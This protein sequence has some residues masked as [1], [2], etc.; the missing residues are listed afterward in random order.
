MWFLIKKKILGQGFNI[1]KSPNFWLKMR[2]LLKSGLN[3]GYLKHTLKKYNPK[4]K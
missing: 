3:R 2:E 4:L 1:E